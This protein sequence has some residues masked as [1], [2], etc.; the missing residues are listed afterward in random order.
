MEELF[1]GHVAVM[2]DRYDR[3]L[4]HHKFDAAV[5]YSGSPHMQFLDDMAYPFKANPHFK[6]WAPLTQVPD[7][8][9]IYRPGEKPVLAY[10]QPDDYW[11]KPPDDPA[12][13]WTAQFDIR[14]LTEKDNARTLMPVGHKAFLGEWQERFSK[15]GKFSANPQGFIHELHYQRAWKTPYE[16]ACMAE[17]SA[18]GALGH[19]AAYL[20]F[21]EDTSEYD[22]HLAYCAACEHTD[23]QLPYD[24]IV[25]L[26]QHAAIL[27]YTYRDTAV[28]PAPQRKSFLIDA[29]ASYNGYASDITRTYSFK[30][31]AFAELIDQ[32]DE[33]QQIICDQVI[34]GASYPELHLDTHRAIGGLLHAAGVI[35]MHGDEAAEAGLTSTFFPHG[36][37]H[38]IG[39]QVHDVGGFMNDAGGERI[40]PPQGHEFLRLTR[41][42]ESDQ[43][44]TIEPGIYFIESLLNKLKDSPL[45]SAVNWTQVEKFIPYGGIRIEDN[46][47]AT[48]NGPINLTRDAFDKLGQSH[49]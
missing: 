9:I 33:L 8:F 29:G 3:A 34:P 32:M 24:N 5:V 31:D 1:A 45:K 39:L 6:C 28:I 48:D 42:V 23:D 27:H 49:S 46:V 26:N 10:F 13:F 19:R 21:C 43:V 14:I 12:G 37:G 30:D 35:T 40:S 22:I 44:M 41:T 15:W 16:L 36:L 47:V 4:E 11:H 17:A 38:Y 18:L 25:A 2:L 7:S 20:A